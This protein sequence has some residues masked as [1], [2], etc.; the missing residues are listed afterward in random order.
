MGTEMHIYGPPGTGKTTTLVQEYI[1][2]EAEQY[3][4]TIPDMN[5]AIAAS[6]SKTAVV[7][8]QS[9][10]SHYFDKPHD[11]VATLNAL[12]H[13]QLGSLTLF[14]N[15]G[16]N[17]ENNPWVEW[18][19]RGHWAYEPEKNSGDDKDDY[20]HAGKSEL[21]GN[22]MIERYSGERQ[23][24]RGTELAKVFLRNTGV[25]IKYSREEYEKFIHD[26]EQFKAEVGC[27]DFVDQLLRPL[28]EQLSPPYG[29]KRLYID[30]AQDLTPLMLALIRM[31][32]DEYGMTLVMAGDDDQCIGESLNGAAAIQWISNP[33]AII[34]VLPQSY[35]VSKEVHKASQVLAR[36]LSVRAEKEWAPASHSGIVASVRGNWKTPTAIANK[37]MELEDTGQSVMVL[38]SCGYIL[39]PVLEAL[40]GRGVRYHNPYRPENWHWQTD[41]NGRGT[42]TYNKVCYLLSRPGLITWRGA[43][44]LE[45]LITNPRDSGLFYSAKEVKERVAEVAKTGDADDEIDEHLVRAHTLAKYRDNPQHYIETMAKAG[46]DNSLAFAFKAWQRYGWSEDRPLV[47]VGTIFSVKGGEADNVILFPDISTAGAMDFRQNKDCT[48]RLFYVGATRAKYNLYIP[49]PVGDNMR[50]G[51]FYPLRVVLE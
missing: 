23:R 2:R 36:R 5:A 18:N 34:R 21:P 22:K 1:A 27:I 8:L 38:A 30:E 50:R 47:T 32:R 14:G 13:R 4:G 16:K 43:D 51:F 49:N 6:F 31:W 45:S 39:G 41:S 35:R 37:I 10:V 9:K 24:I 20:G 44:Y 29:A 42:S 25:A 15:N 11:S 26:Y 28:E 19:K 7:H 40:R 3:G 46:K 17:K 33:D 48:T 12:G